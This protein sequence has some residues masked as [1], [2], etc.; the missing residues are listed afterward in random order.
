[1]RPEQKRIRTKLDEELG[2]LRFQRSEEVL[3][4]A[5]PRSWK[6]RLKAFWNKELEVPL[7]PLGVSLTFLLIVM[8][9][10]LYP[11]QTGETP[12]EHKQLVEAGG[13][14]YWKE[15]YEKAVAANEAADQ[16]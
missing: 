11:K 4:R 8:S 5:F 15:D 9:S 16:S 12:Q 10:F 7:F 3:A 14:T 2:E 1:M 13:N 6:G